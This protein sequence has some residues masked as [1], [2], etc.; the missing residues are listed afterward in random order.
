MHDLGQF[1]APAQ[2]ASGNA[3]VP[4]PGWAGTGD[5]RMDRECRTLRHRARRD[6]ERRAGGLI[7]VA[8][9]AGPGRGE[10]PPRRR[11]ALAGLPRRA[12]TKRTHRARRRAAWTTASTVAGE[13][14]GGSGHGLAVADRTT[15]PCT[16]P[17]ERTTTN[18]I[19]GPAMV[20]VPDLETR[21][22]REVVPVRQQPWPFCNGSTS[23]SRE[24][25]SIERMDGR[26][27]PCGPFLSGKG[28]T[29]CCSIAVRNRE[30]LP[31]GAPNH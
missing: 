26:I 27:V 22:C 2:P 19:R 23:R 29:N 24:H 5:A 30:K 3:G 10:A 20:A 4:V 21:R 28:A 15:R 14:A 11:P 9:W 12:V 18:L 6:N 7:V 8:A 17:R 25:V 1:R 31:A 13:A 16:Q